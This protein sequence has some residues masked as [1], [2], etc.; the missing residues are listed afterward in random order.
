MIICV[1][2]DKNTEFLVVNI[3]ITSNSIYANFDDTNNL[4]KSGKYTLILK[5]NSKYR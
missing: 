5:N 4:M 1:R 2:N 3:L